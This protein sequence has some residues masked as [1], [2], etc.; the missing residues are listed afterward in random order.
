[1]SPE[2]D[3]LGRKEPRATVEEAL[4][5]LCAGDELD[6]AE[7]ERRMH[8]FLRCVKTGEPDVMWIPHRVWRAFYN[9]RPGVMLGSQQAEVLALGRQFKAEDASAAAMKAIESAMAETK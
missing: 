3:F 6:G 5:S 9:R 1:M 7:R 4:S 2:T 8:L